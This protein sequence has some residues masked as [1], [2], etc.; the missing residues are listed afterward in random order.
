MVIEDP[1]AREQSLALAPD[2]VPMLL[3]VSVL[4]LL[5]GIG[6]L[7]RDGDPFVGRTYGAGALSAPS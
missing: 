6:R 4:R 2:L 7:V 3:A 1:T 5:R